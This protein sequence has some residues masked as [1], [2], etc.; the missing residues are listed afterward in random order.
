MIAM[1]LVSALARESTLTVGWTESTSNELAVFAVEKANATF[2][3]LGVDV[4]RCEDQPQLQALVRKTVAEAGYTDT[5][6]VVGPESFGIIAQTIRSEECLDGEDDPGIASVNVIDTGDAYQAIVVLRTGSSRGMGQASASKANGGLDSSICEAASIA[7]QGVGYDINDATAAL[8]CSTRPLLN[9]ST[10]VACER[11]AATVNAAG[12]WFGEDTTSEARA[13]VAGCRVAEALETYAPMVKDGSERA[14]A[15]LSLLLAELELWPH[16][17][18]LTTRWQGASRTTSTARVIAAAF[19]DHATHCLREICPPLTPLSLSLDPTPRF[20]TSLAWRH[21]TSVSRCSATQGSAAFLDILSSTASFKGSADPL[22][23]ALREIPIEDVLP[24]PWESWRR[25][26]M[27]SGTTP[28]RSWGDIDMLDVAAWEQL[29][30][31]DAARMVTALRCDALEPGAPEGLDDEYF[32]VPPSGLPEVE[33]GRL[34]ESMVRVPLPRGVPLPIHRLHPEWWRWQPS[35][36][37]VARRTDS[38]PSEWTLGSMMVAPVPL[39]ADVELR[40]PEEPAPIPLEP[41][42]Q[43]WTIGRALVLRSSSSRLFLL[44]SPEGTLDLLLDVPDVGYSESVSSRVE[45]ST[46]VLANTKWGEFERKARSEQMDQTLALFFN[47]HEMTIG[48]QFSTCGPAPL[49]C[50][51]QIIDAHLNVEFGLT[52][53]LPGPVALFAQL[54]GTVGRSRARYPEISDWVHACIIDPGACPAA[55]SWSASTATAVEAVDRRRVWLGAHHL[56]IEAGLGLRLGWLGLDRWSPALGVVWA[57]SRPDQV[58]V[59]G[60]P[61]GTLEDLGVASL[62]SRPQLLG[63][64][65][66]LEYRSGYLRLGGKLRFELDTPIGRATRTSLEAFIGPRLPVEVWSPRPAVL[67]MAGAT[68]GVGAALDTLAANHADLTVYLVIHL[69]AGLLIRRMKD[70]P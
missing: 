40:L 25:L 26:T 39:Q 9:P 42:R 50:S 35:G 58:Q 24:E 52:P 49:R 16:V 29:A 4:R 27:A 3:R 32:V 46:M 34:K 54:T 10:V 11:L 64:W 1:L 14:L 12:N 6:G 56:T 45:V 57:A 38:D 66:K 67:P 28:T 65:A 22:D 62:V 37:Q 47:A 43:W 18:E 69:D 51:A 48:G 44:G 2:E 30:T 8:A 5:E 63:G 15:E 70:T 55:E 59:R 68:V 21:A 19:A 13:S 41:G 17:V 31:P 61:V 23:V 53:T 33:V 60:A 7:L 20:A 36:I